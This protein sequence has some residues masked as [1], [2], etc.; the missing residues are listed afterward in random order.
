MCSILTTNKK[1]DQL[2]CHYTLSNRGPDSTNSIVHESFV[3]MHNLLSMTGDFTI[4]PIVKNNVVYLFNGEI[5]N[6][7]EYGNYSSDVYMLIDMYEKHQDDFIKHLDG[8][9]AIIIADFN[10][11]TILFSTD[12]FGIKPLYYC[13][14]DNNF[15]A[16]SYKEPLQELGC[17]NIIKCL[18][19]SLMKYNL[20]TYEIIK[21]SNVFD[22]DLN[23]HKN[24]YDDWTNA[25]LNA[26]KKRFYN[27]KHDIIL[28]LSSGH[29]SGAI[30]CAFDLLGIDYISYSFV[31]SEDSSVI[32]E[33]IKRRLKLTR[34][35]QRVYFKDYLN[36]NERE[37][38]KKLI[39]DKCSLITYGENTDFN[40]HT[41]V[42]I[43]DSGAQGLAFLLNHVKRANK[44]IKI[45]ASGQG[46]DEICTNL[47]TYKFGT[48]NPAKFPEDLSSVFPWNNF[49]YGAQSSYLF[50]EE[51]ISG[52]FGI[53]GR[54]P[55]LD[56]KVVQEFLWLKADLK[57]RYYKAPIT[58]FLI[59]NDYPYFSG[60]LGFN[61]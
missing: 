49:F 38:A 27:Q 35:P 40:K 54:Y 18:P 28:P 36:N 60:K 7:L 12:I 59:D 45:L 41:H 39:S 17:K 61:S 20:E 42:G 50:K 37:N 5:Y 13:L 57:N 56:K 23:Q 33:R 53:E 21:I 24:N 9:F 16:C 15:N 55:F 22:F 44:N 1:V 46:G 14:E 3:F 58:N 8:E 32:E 43:E 47:Q 52:G 51:S 2:K 25:F 34:D 11:K 19:N 10:K 4:Q 31:K 48:P 30:S 29:D 6:Y 26:I